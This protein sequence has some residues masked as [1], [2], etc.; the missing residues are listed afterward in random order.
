MKC[1][2]FSLSFFTALALT[3]EPQPVEQ[4]GR[5]VWPSEYV[6][7]LSRPL[8]TGVEGK[9]YLAGV[10]QNLIADQ[11]SL[12]RSAVTR[13]KLSP[14]SIEYPLRLDHEAL[15]ANE[16]DDL[17]ARF[18]KPEI[19]PLRIRRGDKSASSENTCSGLPV[20]R[21]TLLGFVNA[22]PSRIVAR[23]TLCQGTELLHTQQIAAD[24]QEL[25]A[26]V[27]RLVNPI[28]AKL[29]G[30]NYASLRVES[31]PPQASV[32]LDEQ[33]LGKT[34]LDYSYLI[35]GTYRLV[36]KRDGFRAFSEIVQMQSGEKAL[37]KINMQTSPVGASLDITTTPPG[38]KIY[39][40]ADYHGKTPKRIDNIPAGTYRLHL[41]HPEKGEVYRTLT[42]P[43]KNDDVISINENLSGFLADNKP[44]LLG[45]TY[46][47]WY[48]LSLATSAT[49][50]GSSIAFYVWRDY[51]QEQIFARL[52]G[53]SPELYTQDDRD[54]LSQRNREYELRDAYATGF[55]VG[56]ATFA[57]L[58][59]YF[60]VQHLLSQDEG[61][62][63]QRNAPSIGGVEYR[64]GHS[65]GLAGFSTHFYF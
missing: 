28:R 24:E 37:R 50:F 49:L 57:V 9:A 21:Y 47:N 5:V 1:A 16:R 58:S 56:A 35:P 63:M 6:L 14:L 62:V 51:A 32:Y 40:D 48:Y 3:A 59:L 65:S 26:A 54:F 43:E 22:S 13:G 15:P 46:K 23:L 12:Q 52:S 38:A 18:P 30:D 64:L 17:L 33:F 45:I 31:T 19:L 7:E 34:P 4:A 36:L 20:D 2:C 11:L 39:L 25:V 55:M 10:I 42:L 41:L 8:V 29:T 44:G 53:K 27:Q 61:I 60:Y